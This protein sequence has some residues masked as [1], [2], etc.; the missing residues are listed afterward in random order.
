MS[1]NSNKINTQEPDRQGALSVSLSDLSDI[2][3][4]PSGGD[5]L[6]YASGAWTPTSPP[7]IQR[8]AFAG[9]R[10]SSGSFTTST[11]NFDVGDNTIWRNAQMFLYDQT[12]TQTTASSGPYVPAAS[13]AW[14]MHWTLKASTLEG[15]TVRAE[16]VHMAKQLT[17]G[18]RIVY[19]W[20][21]GT[22]VGLPL[23]SSTPIG[24]R[25]EQTV[26]YVTPCFGTFTVGSSD[27]YLGLKV[28][29]KTGTMGL[30]TGNVALSSY[31]ALETIG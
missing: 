11:G 29:E 18:E 10:L 16:A 28:V 14:T 1:H 26:D 25:A 21:V 13:S 8:I 7:G 2:S 24:P 6:G 31:V 3:G 17:T 9:W 23:A 22:S 12:Y 19:Q 30:L 27:V 15:K 20:M 4:T 5:V